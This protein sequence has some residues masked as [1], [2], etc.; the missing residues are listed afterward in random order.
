MFKIISMNSHKLHNI[1]ELQTSV[2]NFIK[3]KKIITFDITTIPWQQNS[4]S[5]AYTHVFISYEE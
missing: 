3:D 2:N 5:G 4:E 1:S